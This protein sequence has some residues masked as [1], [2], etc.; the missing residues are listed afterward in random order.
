MTVDHP[1]RLPTTICWT[2]RVLSGG[3]V[4][5]QTGL[6]LL[7]TRKG[8]VEGPDDIVKKHGVVS[9][10]YVDGALSPVSTQES[11]PPGFVGDLFPSSGADKV[12]WNVLTHARRTIVHPQRRV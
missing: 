5:Y 2:L 10:W 7:V 12:L 8:E 1:V 4:C 9:V 11:G 3:V 6:L